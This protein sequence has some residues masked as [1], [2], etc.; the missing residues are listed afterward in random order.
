MRMVETSPNLS[1]GICKQGL[2]LW[3]LLMP[4]MQRLAPI[5]WPSSRQ[6]QI[7]LGRWTS[8]PC[9]FLCGFLGRW[10]LLNTIERYWTNWGIWTTY[11][12][13]FQLVPCQNMSELCSNLRPWGWSFGQG[14]RQGAD[15]WHRFGT[16]WGVAPLLCGQREEKTKRC[17]CVKIWPKVWIL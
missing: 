13:C 6:S 4:G 12:D 3:Q 7:R 11:F 8:C 10:T 14:V 16:L 2:P 1:G 5:P 9:R 17:S 15:A